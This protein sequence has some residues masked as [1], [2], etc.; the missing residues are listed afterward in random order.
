[1]LLR[2]SIAVLGLLL[3]AAG[4]ASA[5]ITLTTDLK[6]GDK[7]SDIAKIVAHADSPDGIDKVAFKVDAEAPVAVASVP[8]EFA[9][10]TIKTTEGPHTLAITAYSS[11]GQSKN[12]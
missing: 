10:D 1:M 6:N 9:W 2:L 11:N 3:P 4:T 8:Y 12:V 5:D 7:V